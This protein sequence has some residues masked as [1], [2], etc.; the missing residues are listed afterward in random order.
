MDH[1]PFKEGGNKK[2]PGAAVG[3]I[4]WDSLGK[5]NVYPR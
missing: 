4:K 2:L 1:S 5:T 3:G